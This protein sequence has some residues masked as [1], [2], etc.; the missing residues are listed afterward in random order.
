ML[1]ETH[2]FTI[3]VTKIGDWEKARVVIKPPPE[4][5]NDFGWWTSA[6][7]Y[8]LAVTASKSGAGF[9]KALELLCSGA[10]VFKTIH[11]PKAKD[12][13]TIRETP[14]DGESED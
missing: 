11:R 6:C 10:M 7:E 4:A 13:D 8:L 1:E 12:D 3:Q 9:E 2:E 5:E 14:G